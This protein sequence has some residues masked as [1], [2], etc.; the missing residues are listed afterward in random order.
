MHDEQREDD[1]VQGVG[2]EGQLERGGE[3]RATRRPYVEHFA[4]AA[5][6]PRRAVDT[7][8]RWFKTNPAGQSNKSE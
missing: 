2:A 5:N 4:A 6:A 1:E 7:Q 3:V 8:A